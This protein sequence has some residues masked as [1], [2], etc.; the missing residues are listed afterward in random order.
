ML[1]K[2][3]AA[4]IDSDILQNSAEGIETVVRFGEKIGAAL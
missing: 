3:D 1:L 4:V 2:K